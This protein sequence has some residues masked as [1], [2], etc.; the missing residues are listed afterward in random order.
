MA[1]L[2]PMDGN[3]FAE[4]PMDEIT[5]LDINQDGNMYFDI[6]HAWDASFE[7]SQADSETIPIDTSLH[8]LVPTTFDQS[9]VTVPEHLAE[10]SS[11][12][13]LRFSKLRTIPNIWTM[14]TQKT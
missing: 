14:G 10:A 5:P 1:S 8:A 7:Q 6:P 9:V 3:L 12:I 13:L 11:R 2:E 4:V